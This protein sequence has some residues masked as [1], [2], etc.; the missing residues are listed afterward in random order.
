[1]ILIKK[2]FELR[3]KIE[4]YKVI[5]NLLIS[6]IMGIVFIFN[7]NLFIKYLGLILWYSFIGI[8]VFMFLN[9]DDVW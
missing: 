7:L 9:F 5:N 1:M 8:L 6:I 3:R 2:F 4:F